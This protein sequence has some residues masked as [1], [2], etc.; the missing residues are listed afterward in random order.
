MITA[1]GITRN[2]KGEAVQDM[3]GRM[4]AWARPPA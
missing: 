1:R 2:Q 3:T 4:L